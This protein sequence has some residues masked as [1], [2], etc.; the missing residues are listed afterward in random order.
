MTTRQKVRLGLFAAIAVLL[1][2]ALAD[3][4]GLRVSETGVVSPTG[5]VPIPHGNHVHYVP[6]GW[7]GEP[8]ISNF[9]TS[10]PPEGMTVSPDGQIVP[11]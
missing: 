2:F 6:N 3:A 7:N 4:L 8:S 10:P 1:G 9:P 11:R 5:Y